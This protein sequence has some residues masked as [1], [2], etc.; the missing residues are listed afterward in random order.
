MPH[1][2]GVGAVALIIGLAGTAPAVTFGS[3]PTAP[4][5]VIN[6]GLDDIY[7][8]GTTSRNGLYDATLYL[9]GGPA[10]IEVSYLGSEAGF[11]NESWWGGALFAKTTGLAG[12]CVWDKDGLLNELGS[13]KQTFTNVASGA[14]EFFFCSPFGDAI[15]DGTNPDPKTGGLGPN[16]F[17]T[18]ENENAAGGQVAYPWFDDD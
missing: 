4:A 8:A 2:T 7:G 6:D 12:T 16:F 15:N 13:L 9:I 1:S 11:E 5:P 18:F 17:V 3:I 14:L 10:D